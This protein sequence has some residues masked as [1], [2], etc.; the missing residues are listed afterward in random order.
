M[1]N[2]RLGRRSGRNPKNVRERVLAA[3]SIGI[4]RGLCRKKDITYRHQELRYH[5]YPEDRVETDGSE[6]HST[7]DNLTDHP[8]PLPSTRIIER[9][10][11]LLKYVCSLQ[12]EGLLC[13]SADQEKRDH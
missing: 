11:Y 8:C 2:L 5:I 1:A 9:R 10:D 3:F 12:D 6:G 4:I 7:R 13:I